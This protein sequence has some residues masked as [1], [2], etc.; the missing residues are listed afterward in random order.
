MSDLV[1]LHLDKV[2]A[3]YGSAQVLFG[4]SLDVPAGA[5]IALLGRNGAGKTTT[6]KSVMRMEVQSTGTIE[7]DGEDIRGLS[8]YRIAR[9]GVGYVPGDRRIL[10]EMSVRENL[11]LGRYT[12]NSER[13]SPELDSVLEYFPMLRPLLS[14]QGGHFKRRRA[15]DADNRALSYR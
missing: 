7:F 2:C 4:V 9:A 6:L 5:I 13:P 15:T 12:A 8:T 11:E 14:R 10:P 3:Y 1:I